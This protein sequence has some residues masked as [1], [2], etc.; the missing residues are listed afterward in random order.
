MKIEICDIKKI[1]SQIFIIPLFQGEEHIKINGG[2]GSKVLKIIRHS[3]FKGKLFE[4]I[5]TATEFE[6]PRFIMLIGLGERKNFVINDLW[7]ASGMAAKICADK[8]I[9]YYGLYLDSVDAGDAAVSSLIEGFIMGTYRF[10]GFKSDKSK[11]KEIRCIDLYGMKKNKGQNPL[12]AATKAMYIARKVNYYRNVINS[13]A[14]YLTPK[15]LAG[16][17]SEMVKGKKIK[18]RIFGISDLRRMGMGGILAVSRGSAEL[19]RFVVL[20]YNP[21]NAKKTVVLVG[22][23]V[24]FDSGGISLKPWENMDKMKY[25]M[26]GAGAVIGTLDVISE[27]KPKIRVIGLIPVTEN[28]PGGRAYKPG[29]IIKMHSGKTVEVISTDA[30]GRMILADALSYSKRFHPNAIVDIATLTGACVIALGNE[31]SGVMGNNK[32]LIETIKSAGT[33]TG[34]RVWE[35]P[36]WKEYEE[37]IR[38]DHADIKNVGGRSAG[39]ITG[40]MFLKQFVGDIPWAHLDVA[41]TAWLEQE[42]PYAVTGATGIGIRLLTRFVEKFS[43]Y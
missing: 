38:S 4:N 9:Q 37:L 5:L 20:D 13:P 10:I 25:D 34:E 1:R 31:A 7:K 28:L 36:M 42:K 8:G 11:R 26:A 6:H 17:A 2:F 43:Q 41:G 27:V 3:G 16:I 15:R 24:T 33:E 32:M 29:D 12:S 23:G 18:C 19:P 40:A 30:E 39:T 35:L 22:K 21:A 14:N